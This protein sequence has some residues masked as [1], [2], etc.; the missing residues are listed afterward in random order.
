MLAALGSPDPFCAAIE[1]NVH[2]ADAPC[3]P[4]C[5]PLRSRVANRKE[6]PDHVNTALEIL[7]ASLGMRLTPEELEW[8]SMALKEKAEQKWREA[9]SEIP[10]LAGYRDAWEPVSR[11]AA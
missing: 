8:L 7:A 1:K 11:D 6:E 10:V 9:G 3:L 4:R 5:I 2:L